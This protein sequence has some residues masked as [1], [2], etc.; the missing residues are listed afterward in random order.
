MQDN[1]EYINVIGAG[2]AGSEAA[3]LLASFGIKVRLY[4]MKPV[5]QLCR[6]GMQ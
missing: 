4:E 2:L 1:K 5:R 3:K 6:T